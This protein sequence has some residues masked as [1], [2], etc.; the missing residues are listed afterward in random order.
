MQLP[1]RSPPNNNDIA[2]STNNNNLISHS[3]HLRTY[4]NNTAR[5][6]QTVQLEE[7]VIVL[8]QHFEKASEAFR[9]RVLQ[10]I[11]GGIDILDQEQRNVNIIQDPPSMRGRC[12]Y[13]RGGKRLSTGA[14]I[15]DKELRDQKKFADKEARSKQILMRPA[16]S[17]NTRTNRPA[18][19]PMIDSINIPSLHQVDHLS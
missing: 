1:R 5:N 16:E 17:G 18:T 6:T 13:E 19:S 4:L 15:A 12:T 9:A 7:K 2:R 3:D 11:Q 14:E 10:E 8:N